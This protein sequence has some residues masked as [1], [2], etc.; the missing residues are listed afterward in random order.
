MRNPNKSEFFTFDPTDSGMQGVSGFFTLNVSGAREIVIG[1]SNGNPADVDW[2]ISNQSYNELTDITTAADFR[3][4]AAYFP[5]QNGKSSI[6]VHS[7]DEY[8]TIYAKDG[9]KG[10][11]LLHVWVIR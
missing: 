5:I 11:T 9:A 6:V 7:N 2:V 10:G 4:G 8:L 3:D 1:T